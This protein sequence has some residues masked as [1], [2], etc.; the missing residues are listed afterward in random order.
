ME[1]KPSSSSKC[2]SCNTFRTVL[3]SAIVSICV[4]QLSL[5][6]EPNTQYPPRAHEVQST[7]T[8]P[9]PVVVE[10]SVPAVVSIVVSAKVP[11]IE[12]Y[13]EELQ[14]PWKGF[15]I[16]RTRQ[17]G[18][19]LEEVGGG[20]G[21]FVSR[22]GYIVT[23]KHVVSDESAEYSVVTNEGDTYKARVIAKDPFFDIAVVKIDGHDDF[24][25]LSFVKEDSLRLGETVIAIGNAL[26]EFPNSV[27]VGVVSGLS[28]NIVAGDGRSFNE[29]LEGV[30]QTD[31]AINR[32]NSGGPLLNDQGLVAGVNVAVAGGGEN[33]G[34]AIPGG[35]VRNIVE[36]VRENGRIVRPFLGVRYRPLTEKEADALG[37][38][39]GRGVVI[40]SGKT[41]DDVAVLPHSPADVAGFKEGDVLLTLDGES[42]GTNRSLVSLIRKYRVG[43]TAIITFLRDGI[44]QTREVTFT[45]ATE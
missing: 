37:V 3:V 18:T 35:I 20:S 36:S 19:K 2:A 26:A 32:G 14:G 28:R 40:I 15:Q 45:E 13:F 25:S 23:N 9:I 33:I 44:K 31:A 22:D 5:F 8:R 29:S 34:F 12:R 41:K 1:E 6:F 21:F 4:V 16:P 38:E 7:E 24:P 27:S 42:I 39:T 30:I 10:K 11:V 43:E 17:V